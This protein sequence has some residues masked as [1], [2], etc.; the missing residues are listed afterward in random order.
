MKLPRLESSESVALEGERRALLP[1]DKTSP[2][3]KQGSG[4]E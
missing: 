3:I 2:S 4:E 1:D